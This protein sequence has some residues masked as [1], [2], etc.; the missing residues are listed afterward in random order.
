MAALRYRDEH[1]KVG[2]LQKPK[3]SDDYHQILDFLGASH[4]RVFNSP[5]LLLL[6]VEMVINPPWIMPLLVTKGLASPKANN[7]WLIKSTHVA[8]VVPKSVVGSS[9]SIASSKLLPF[10]VQHQQDFM[11]CCMK[12]IPI[13]AEVSCVQVETQADWMVLYS[14]YF[15]PHETKSSPTSRILSLV[16]VKVY[17]QDKGFSIVRDED[18]H[19]LNKEDIHAYQSHTVLVNAD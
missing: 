17:L 6:R 3:G 9:F 8:E 19:E 4:I 13:C 10:D 7:F 16:K 14:S 11:M 12:K 2:Y 18:M 5:M 15:N 1:N